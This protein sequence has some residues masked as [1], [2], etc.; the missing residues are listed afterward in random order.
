MR[1]FDFL[2]FYPMASFK[3]REVTDFTWQTPLERATILAAISST[4]LLMSGLEIICFL[5][6]RINIL[7]IYYVVFLFLV[8]G[9]VMVF[10]FNYIYIKR[11]RYEYIISPQYKSFKFS[12]TAGVIICF[13]VFIFSIL[14]TVIIGAIQ[15]NLLKN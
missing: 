13:L 4:C 11:K 14:A 3:K 5:V 1:V 9:I 7:D 8:G 12:V 15:Y 10:L 6:F 2:V